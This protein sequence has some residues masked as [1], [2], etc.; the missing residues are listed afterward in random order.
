MRAEVKKKSNE[1]FTL[2]E[3]L[4]V[5]LVIAVLIFL[6]VPNLGKQRTAIEARGDDAFVKVVTTQSELFVLNES[7]PPTYEEL[8]AGNY[9]TAEQVAKAKKLGITLKNMNEPK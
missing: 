1:G 6:F 3:M 2:I 8:L 5:L 7:R 9:L 4:V